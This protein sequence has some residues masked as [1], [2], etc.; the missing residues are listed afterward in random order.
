[1]K[2]TKPR[3]AQSGWA[4]LESVVATALLGWIVVLV[5]AMAQDIQREESST[6]PSAVLAPSQLALLGHALSHHQLPVPDDA[7]PSPGRAGY[8]EG[9]LPA[10]R[11]GLAVGDRRIRYLVNAEL[12]GPAAI[13]KP[14][15]LNLTGGQ[16]VVRDRPGT[17]DFCASLLQKEL[18]RTALPHGFRTAFAVQQ[19]T[20]TRS[21]AW[22]SLPHV[23]LGDTTPETPPVAVRLHTLQSGFTELATRLRCFQQLDEITRNVKM[24]GAL[25]DMS[26]LAQQELQRRTL[27]VRKND[28]AIENLTWRLTNVSVD[29]ASAY[30]RFALSLKKIDQS[31]SLASVSAAAGL[32]IVSGRHSGVLAQLGD[33]L[34]EAEAAVPDLEAGVTT[35]KAYVEQLDREAR[36]HV[37]AANR[38]QGAGD[39][40]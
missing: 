38:A 6:Q 31:K 3:H 20:D 28:Y 26:R 32:F 8:L 17:V 37:E 35:A 14:D 19:A 22:V 29:V 30:I 24:A 18:S 13:Y 36:I 23:W 9:W 5:V 21:G 10:T 40:P 2:A 16:V 15:P 25:M 7:V 1:M 12:T 27:A 11:L 4:L 34:H 33:A 39:T